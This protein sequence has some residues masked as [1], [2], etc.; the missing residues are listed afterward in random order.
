MASHQLFVKDKE[1]LHLR[2]HAFNP[3]VPVLI[4]DPIPSCS[5]EAEFPRMEYG[6][7]ALPEKTRNKNR[8]NG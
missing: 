8:F 6:L 3:S 2:I 1:K 4:P 7:T 5:Q